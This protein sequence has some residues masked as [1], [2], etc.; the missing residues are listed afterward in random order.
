MPLALLPAMGTYMDRCERC[1][2]YFA[3]NSYRVVSEDDGLM[4]LDMI[5]C[6]G[7]YLEASELGLDA[8]RIEIS[9]IALH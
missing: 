1:R 7:C 2:E 3:G 5:V 4:L 9:Q 6:Y 8:E